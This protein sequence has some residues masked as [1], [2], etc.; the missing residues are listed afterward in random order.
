MGHGLPLGGV[1]SLFGKQWHLKNQ[2]KN[3]EELSDI[4]NPESLK[5]TG[6]QIAQKTENRTPLIYSSEK[7]SAIGY[8]WKIAFNENVKLHAF[9]NLFPEANHNEI[10]A[11]E[12]VEKPLHVITLEDKT[13]HPRIKE[14]FRVFKSIVEKHKLELTNVNVKQRNT[15]EKI[16]NFILLAN[17]TVYYYA[18]INDIDPEPVKLIEEFKKLISYKKED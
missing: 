11:Y 13:D 2:K 17:W 16:I 14:R 15:T 18:K 9:S 3:L 1:G 8:Y 12:T 5:P 4:L 6:K 7:N 10:E